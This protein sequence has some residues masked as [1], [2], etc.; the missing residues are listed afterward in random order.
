[1]GAT[2]KAKAQRCSTRWRRLTSRLERIGSSGF[3][4]SAARVADLN[5]AGVGICVD[6]LAPGVEWAPRRSG[7][8]TR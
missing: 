3:G 2:M 8:P 1:M 4:F 6:M 7:A 5:A